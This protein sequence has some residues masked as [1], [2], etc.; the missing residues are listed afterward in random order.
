MTPK[1]VNFTIIC[2][3]NC[4]FLVFN[5]EIYTRYIKKTLIKDADLLV[6]FLSRTSL[7]DGLSTLSIRK[8]LAYFIPKT[9]HYNDVI[10][11]AD[12][13]VDSISLVLQGEIEICSKANGNSIGLVK[14]GVG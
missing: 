12:S 5:E 2:E 14:L 13:P 9:F 11:E 7:F 10:Y 6:H 1:F 3:S 8:Y 4:S